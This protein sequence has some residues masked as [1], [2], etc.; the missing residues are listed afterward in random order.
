MPTDRASR[1]PVVTG[2][3]IDRVR[4]RMKYAADSAEAAHLHLQNS[5]DCRQAS[6]EYRAVSPRRTG[7][8]IRERS[9]RCGK[10]MSLFGSIAVTVTVAMSSGFDLAAAAFAGL[11]VLLARPIFTLA[12]RGV[13]A[14]TAIEAYERHRLLSGGGPLVRALQVGSV[15]ARPDLDAGQATWLAYAATLPAEV[16]AESLTG[17]VQRREVRQA[18]TAATALDAYVQ[19][20]T[21]QAAANMPADTWLAEEQ[22][23]RAGLLEAGVELPEAT[24]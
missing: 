20:I 21:G 16:L 7:P 6:S 3:D 14:R 22:R 1:R 18:H 11:L 9:R 19:H 12:W 10:Q 17:A 13:I 8:S 5:L 23:L 15:T 24:P 4:M 2:A